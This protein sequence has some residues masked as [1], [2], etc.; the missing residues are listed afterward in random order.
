MAEENKT[1]LFEKNDETFVSLST[2]LQ[3]L[4]NSTCFECSSLHPLE[5]G[6]TKV[7]RSG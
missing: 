6:G 1:Y 5:D 4:H 7:A 2:D 3:L